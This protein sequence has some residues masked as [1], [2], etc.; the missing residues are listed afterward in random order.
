MLVPIKS[1]IAVTDQFFVPAAVPELTPVCQVIFDTSTLSVAVP[2][3]AIVELLIRT[4]VI[5][6]ETTVRE[7][8][9]VSTVFAAAF[10]TMTDFVAL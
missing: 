8:G 5:A 1:G 7:G 9:V 10:V 2:V 4:P 6:G 3:T